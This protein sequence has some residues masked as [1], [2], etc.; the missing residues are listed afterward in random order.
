MSEPVLELRSISKNFGS[1]EALKDVNLTVPHGSLIVL[2][3]PAGA[4]KTTTIRNLL[5]FANATSG[6]ATIDGI[7]CRKNAE[8]LQNRIGYLPGEIAF[9]DNMT[10]MQFLTFMGD[11]RSTKDTNRRDELLVRFEL[12]TTGKIKKMSK[13]MKQKLAII[14]AFMHDPSI[15]ILDEPT[16]GLDPFMQTIFMELLREEKGR[17]KTIMMSSHIFEEVQRICDRAGIIKDG[18]IVA[19]EDIQS[20]NEVKQMSYVVSVSDP[21][22]VEK[23]MGRGLNMEKISN[24][25]LSVTVRHNYQEL[26]AA[27]ADC[28]VVGLE[29]QS[30]SLED[31]FMKYYGKEVE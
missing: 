25:R 5:G 30:Q 24:R 4:G 23:L 20:L 16:S 12:D 18:R 6:T 15:Y 13:G 19:V 1:N 27:L 9:L 11:M 7:D 31:V 14:A 2:L 8:K 28:S 10:G 3:G 17:G 29:S 21:A 26:F 22:D